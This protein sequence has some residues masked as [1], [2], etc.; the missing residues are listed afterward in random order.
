M[1]LFGSIERMENHQPRAFFEP[2]EPFE[3]E[4]PQQQDPHQQKPLL[5]HPIF[6]DI[7]GPLYG[8]ANFEH[9]DPPSSQVSYP[10]IF[11]IIKNV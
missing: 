4:P 8:E 6:K 5:F 2:N 7:H 11:P 9:H 10:V 1:P 3:Q